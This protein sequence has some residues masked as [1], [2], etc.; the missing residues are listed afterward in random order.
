M[1]E[2][3]PECFT[4]KTTDSFEYIINGTI[5][6]FIDMKKHKTCIT[7]CFISRDISPFNE[8]VYLRQCGF[9]TI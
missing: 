1:K 2:D 7:V 6:T 9:I 4:I 3:L 5:Q 8:E